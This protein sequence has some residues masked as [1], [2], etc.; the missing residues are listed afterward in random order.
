MAS[1]YLYRFQTSGMINQYKFYTPMET[2]YPEGEG[3]PGDNFF[4]GKFLMRTIKY[5]LSI[6]TIAS[7]ELSRK[8]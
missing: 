8:F 6:W 7:L 3:E 5:F 4:T 1:E 2:S